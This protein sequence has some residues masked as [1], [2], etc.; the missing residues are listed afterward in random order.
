VREIARRLVDGVWTTVDVDEA[1]GGGGDL[2]P[3]V[4]I[5]GTD[6]DAVPLTVE[7]AANQQNDLFLVDTED[8]GTTMLRVTPDGSGGAGSISMHGAGGVVIELDAGALSLIAPTE[9]LLKPPSSEPDDAL[10]NQFGITL[11][12]LDDTPGDASV[13]F[14]M[15]DSD[16]NIVTVKIPLTVDGSITGGWPVREFITAYHRPKAESG[17][18]NVAPADGAGSN[19][20][21]PFGVRTSDN[22]NGSWIEWFVSLKAGTYALNVRGFPYNGAGILTF[23]LNGTDIDQAPYN[24]ASASSD[25]YSGVADGFAAADEVCSDLEIPADGVYVLRATVDGKNGSSSGFATNLV[26]VALDMVVA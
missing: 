1:G 17:F 19:G 12:W 24:A 18:D 8:S 6:V 23:S 3:P 11:P 20:V 13:N 26:Y 5:E 4:L 16:E 14:K 22:A 10:L 9:M 25:Q 21:T 15:L 2:T 7:G